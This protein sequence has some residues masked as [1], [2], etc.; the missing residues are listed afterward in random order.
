ML[1]LEYHVVGQETRNLSNFYCLQY[2]MN[3]YYLHASPYEA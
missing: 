2:A 3:I 1:F